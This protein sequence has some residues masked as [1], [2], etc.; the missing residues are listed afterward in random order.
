MRKNQKGQSLFELVLAV[1]VVG[2]VMV[3]LVRLVS[4]T[5]NNTTFAR[6]RT[7]ALRHTQEA[8]EWLRGQRD[9]NWGQFLGRS[10]VAGSKYCLQSLSFSANGA[11]GSGAT[12]DNLFTR[13]G[14]LARSTEPLTGR[15][16]VEVVVTTG[17][18]DS[19]GYHESRVSTVLTDWRT[20]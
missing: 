20:Y 7:L 10:S 19:E 2:V 6:D 5:I 14:V 11:C 8:V 18:S 17:W 15:E 16:L 9:A 3:V 1:V 13:E 4:K 12:I